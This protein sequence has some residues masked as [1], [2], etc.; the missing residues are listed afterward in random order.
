MREERKPPNTMARVC[1][2]LLPYDRTRRA[3]PTTHGGRA[4]GERRSIHGTALGVVTA[5]QI[6]RR[7]LT[8]PPAVPNALRQVSEVPFGA[9]AS[10]ATD[11]A[12][13]PPHIAASG[14]DAMFS[15]PSTHP[16]PDPLQVLTYGARAAHISRGIWHSTCTPKKHTT[17]PLHTTAPRL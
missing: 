6:A 2:G 3:S 16:C 17:S 15:P 1:H 11:T 9:H 13:T 5:Q 10:S 4:S 12:Y 7:A 8:C 14:Q